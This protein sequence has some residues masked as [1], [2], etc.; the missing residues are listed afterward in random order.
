MPDCVLTAGDRLSP[1]DPVL[2]R[3]PEKRLEGHR[4]TKHSRDWLL[5]GSEFCNKLTTGIWYTEVKASFIT[6][7][8]EARDYE[9]AENTHNPKV[10]GTNFEG[11]HSPVHKYTI[12]IPSVQTQFHL[13]NTLVLNA[14]KVVPFLKSFQILFSKITYLG[15]LGIQLLLSFSKAKICFN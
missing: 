5:C 9:A 2:V 15:H 3:Q 13:K 4:N 6:L 1:S 10:H 8:G 14:V 12:Q 11:K 7:G